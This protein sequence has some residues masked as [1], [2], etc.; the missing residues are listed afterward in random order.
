MHVHR[1]MMD[2]MLV[3]EFGDW[4]VTLVVVP[5]TT[6]LRIMSAYWLKHFFSQKSLVFPV[7]L[8]RLSS[9]FESSGFALIWP[10]WLAGHENQMYIVSL[11][12][13]KKEGFCF[14]KVAYLFTSL[15]QWLAYVLS[16]FERRFTHVSHH[17]F[18]SWFVV[19]FEAVFMLH[20]LVFVIKCERNSEIM[21]KWFLTM[22]MESYNVWWCAWFEMFDLFDDTNSG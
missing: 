5:C 16:H 17:E 12:K 22:S 1:S 13:K 4:F 8:F 19:A 15:I 6:D 21:L 11:G 18:E 2:S 3:F 14:D 9:G 10:L 7:L 20:L